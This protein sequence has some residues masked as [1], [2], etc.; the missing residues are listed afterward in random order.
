MRKNIFLGLFIIVGVFIGVIVCR[1]NSQKHNLNKGT[2]DNPYFIGDKIKISDL[3]D[4]FDQDTE[5]LTFDLEIKVNKKIST[6][7]GNEALNSQGYDTYTY[8]PIAEIT[9][10]LNGKYDNSIISDNVFK[11]STVNDNLENGASSFVNDKMES[12][13]EIY[14]G[15]E[16]T[17]Y[18]T[19]QYDQ[20]GSNPEI[21]YLLIEYLT[22]DYKTKSVYIK[23]D[24]NNSKVKN[25]AATEEEKIYNSANIA[26]NKGYYTIAKNLYNEV[27]NYKDAKENYEKMINTLK[28]YNGTYYGESTDRKG[29]FYNIFIQDGEVRVQLKDSSTNI[30]K[31]ELYSYGKDKNTE[32]PILAFSEA[33]T[34]LFKVVNDTKYGDGYAIQKLSDGSYLVAAT[35]GSEYTTFN[36]FYNK[37]NST[38]ENQDMFK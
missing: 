9:F 22:K 23:L 7:D 10:K 4:R 2:R 19:R 21:I 14:T 6:Y 1:N 26:K 34:S 5:N 27:I 36:G 18:A 24:D 31:Y 3:L 35:A 38:V 15:K 37:I 30:S 11:I 16:Y 32:N 25:N 20:D 29:V 8:I 28:D 13:T 33:K 12:K 17:Y